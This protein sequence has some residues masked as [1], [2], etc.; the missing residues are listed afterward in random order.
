[1]V[2]NQIMINHTQK[3]IVVMVINQSVIAVTEL[4]AFILR[5]LETTQLENNNDD[6]PYTLSSS[7]LM[8]S[9]VAPM[10]CRVQ[11]S[12]VVVAHNRGYLCVTMSP[13]LD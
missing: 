5:F 12:R 9:S 3:V 6:P 4:Y 10:G 11:N 8:N 2:V 1:M 13:G 7:T